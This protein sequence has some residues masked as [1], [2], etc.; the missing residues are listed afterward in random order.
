MK[1]L[2]YLGLGS[3]LGDRVMNL[4][5][6]LEQLEPFAHVLRTSRIYETPPWGYLDQPAFLNQVVEIETDLSPQELLGYIKGIEE[7]MGRVKSVLNGPRLID[8]DLLFYDDLV[9]DLPGLAIPHPRM[10]GRGFV[11]VPLSELAP[12]FIHPLFKE[13]ILEMSARVDRAGIRIYL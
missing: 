8:L 7:N 5:Q 10:E 2:V 4:R 9:I 13:T 1:H 6:A 3:N 11:L 12:D